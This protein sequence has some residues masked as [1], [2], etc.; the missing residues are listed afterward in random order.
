RPDSESI[1]RVTIQKGRGKRE[2]GSGRSGNPARSRASRFPL[3][4]SRAAVLTLFVAP[5]VGVGAQGAT[6]T[7]MPTP[8]TV[9]WGYYDAA[10]APVLHIRSGDVIVVGT[11]I[12]S[13]PERL[14]A[15]GVKPED[16]EHSLRD[17]TT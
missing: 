15:A 1:H 16:V 6:H 14:E 3:P 5:L 10:A 12:T 4:A 11:L 8:T 9:A 17:I 13:P 7:L 2:A